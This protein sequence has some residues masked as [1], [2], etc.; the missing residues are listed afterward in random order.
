MASNSKDWYPYEKGKF[1]HSDRHTQ[2]EDNMK[3]HGVHDGHLSAMEIHLEHS[4]SQPQGEPT[5]LTP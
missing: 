3:R 2:R 5:L 4:P 1:E